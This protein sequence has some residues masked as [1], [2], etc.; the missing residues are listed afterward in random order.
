MW[1]TTSRLVPFRTDAYPSHVPGLPPT[2]AQTATTPPALPVV[3]RGRST[4]S[5]FTADPAGWAASRVT[6]G[7]T[8]A[9]GR[10]SEVVVV[11]D[12]CELPQAARKSAAP[13]DAA[14]TQRRPAR[15][16]VG[17]VVCIF[18]WC[19]HPAPHKRPES[20]RRQP[21]R[22]GFATIT[23]GST[24][25]ARRGG[26]AGFRPADPSEDEEEHRSW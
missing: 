11:V 3:R 20:S 23:P 19:P 16:W 22:R 12:A 18:G 14:M 24:E 9:D 7:D 17:S 8:A 21:T 5:T 15:R 10:C 25:G 13:E 2:S 4:L 26:G 1:I 6:V